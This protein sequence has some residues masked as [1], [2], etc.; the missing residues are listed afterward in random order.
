MRM[1]SVK[2]FSTRVGFGVLIFLK[3]V[4]SRSGSRLGEPLREA[5]F[6]CKAARVFQTDITYLCRRLK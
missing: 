1:N 3:S 5:E 6:S 4:D 2:L